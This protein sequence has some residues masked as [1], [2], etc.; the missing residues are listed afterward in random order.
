[1]A[2]PDSD[3]EPAVD[4]WSTSHLLPV[5]GQPTRA[6]PR[7]QPRGQGGLESLHATYPDISDLQSRPSSYF[8][9]RTTLTTHNETVDGLSHSILAKS[10]GVTHTFAGYD[11]VVCETHE[12]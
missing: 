1:M 9:E 3:Y 4:L 7:G 6:Q 8:T 12:R 10:S 11:K 5:H 2:G